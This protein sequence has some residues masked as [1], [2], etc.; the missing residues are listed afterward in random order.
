MHVYQGHA[1]L[2]TKRELSLVHSGEKNLW[3]GEVAGMFRTQVGAS[4]DVRYMCSLPPMSKLA[5][6]ASIIG[7]FPLDVR[8]GVGLPF[9]VDLDEYGG[10]KPEQGLDVR[11]DSDLIGSSLEF[12][13][14][15]SLDA[16]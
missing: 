6:R 9:F 3:C 5:L 8:L 12:L 4:S 7:L 1:C 15:R 11:E 10:C 13:L 14:D 16:V 2:H